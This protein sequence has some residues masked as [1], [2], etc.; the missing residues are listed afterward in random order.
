MLSSTRV[1]SALQRLWGCCAR[2]KRT[3]PLV[4]VVALL[5]A[6][7]ACF[8][9]RGT[10]VK[11]ENHTAVPVKVHV[12]SVSL[13]FSGTYT[14]SASYAGLATTPLQPGE[15]VRFATLIHPKR[16]YG[17]QAKYLVAAVAETNQVVYE[18][19]F[20]WDELDALGWRV[21]IEPEQGEAAQSSGTTH[22][23]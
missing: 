14:P 12:K 11:F 8:G 5:T 9:D 21:V 3:L 10:V 16:E 7:V 22:L 13:D 17:I 2:W 19:V 18:R 20:T 1:S 15:T 4:L 23:P 6:G